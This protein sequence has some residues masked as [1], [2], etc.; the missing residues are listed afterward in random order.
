[1]VAGAIAKGIKV[2]ILSCLWQRRLQ[3]G[4]LLKT[5]SR[6]RKN[7][8]LRQGPLRYCQLISKKFALDCI[9]SRDE[10]FHI[11]TDQTTGDLHHCK[12]RVPRLSNVADAEDIRVDCFKFL[13]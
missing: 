10:L 7:R 8:L 12:S 2:L 4:S 6:G 13:A 5:K 1:M 9:D 11:I 3:L